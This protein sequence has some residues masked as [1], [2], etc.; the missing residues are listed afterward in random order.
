MGVFV[1]RSF[2]SRKRILLHFN[3]N[4]LGSVNTVDSIL[5]LGMNEHFFFFP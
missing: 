1:F 5:K 3:Y 2:Q 4:I